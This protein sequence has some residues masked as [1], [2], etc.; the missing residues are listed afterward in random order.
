[1][2]LSIRSLAA[3][4][5]LACAI[6][7]GCRSSAPSAMESAE[8]T[9]SSPSSASAPTVAAS[10]QGPSVSS[11]TQTASPETP[12]RPPATTSPSPK[13]TTPTPTSDLAGPEARTVDTARDAVIDQAL[14][15]VR[16]CHQATGRSG[17][18]RTRIVLRLRKD[19]TVKAVDVTATGTLDRKI[20][21]CIEQRIS[22][23]RFRM[24]EDTPRFL[25]F[26]VVLPE[27]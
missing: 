24:R 9:A 23:Q 21:P 12:P 16:A 6:F 4:P 25:S 5:M 1:M 8:P 7:L 22:K 18:G 13:P 19:G 2:S 3:F 10:S 27:K 11:S 15:H 26:P 20:A 14:P 17:A